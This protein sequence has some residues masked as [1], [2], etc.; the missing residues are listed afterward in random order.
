MSIER[1]T[2]KAAIKA[3]GD[4]GSFEAVIATL[5]VL[6]KDR[7]IVE[8]GAFGNAVASVMPAHDG[9]SVPLGKVSVK[10]DG[11]SAIAVGQ[12]NL[13]IEKARDWSSSLKFDLATPPSI[14]EWSW[15]F[16]IPPGGAQ[17]E[18]RDGEQVRILKRVD[19]IEVSPVLRGASIGTGTISAKGEDDPPPLV[20][21]ITIAT[22]DVEKL[23]AEIRKNAEGRKGRGRTPLGKDV[24]IATVEMAEQ[25]AKMLDELAIMIDEN[26]LPEDPTMRAAAE[27]FAHMSLRHRVVA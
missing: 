18:E 23:V 11:A 24:R 5:G 8:P 4:D 7:D 27:F 21:R 12:F 16:N 6:D 20:E 13:E 2:V 22:G 25:V 9:T 14:Q 19:L 15:G 26:V 17:F 3:A 1:K 10:E